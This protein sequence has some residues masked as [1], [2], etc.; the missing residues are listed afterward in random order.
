MLAGSSVGEELPGN[1]RPAGPHP[2]AGLTLWHPQISTAPR[3]YREGNIQCLQSSE[4]KSKTPLSSHLPNSQ[5]LKVKDLPPS[6]ATKLETRQMVL[7]PGVAQDGDRMGNRL[8]YGFKDTGMA[9]QGVSP[10]R[11]THLGVSGMD[12]LIKL[13]A[14]VADG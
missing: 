11:L 10:R 3:V 6:M 12:A 1:F 7:F 8:C 13:L 9:P 14:W 5:V 4:S 2:A